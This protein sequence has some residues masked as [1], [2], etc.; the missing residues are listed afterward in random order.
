MA[1]NGLIELYPEIFVYKGATNLG[2]IISWEDGIP[3]A[4]LIDSGT[5]DA[6]AGKVY[7]A[8][9]ERFP[10][11][12]I[13]VIINTHSHADHCGGNAWFYEHC[14]PEGKLRIWAT[15]AEKS[16]I[17]TPLNQSA[18]ASGG[19]PLPEFKASYYIARKSTV[20][21]VIHDG[22]EVTISAPDAETELRL[23]FVPL[24]GHYMDMVGVLCI[25][26]GREEAFFAGDGIFGRDML[27]NYWVPFLFDVKAFKE[28]LA[29]MEKMQCTYYIP[30]H[31]EINRDISELVELN[32]ISVISNE[33]AIIQ[34][35]KTPHTA[36]DTLKEFADINDIPLR[37]SQH[38]F[39]GSTLRSYISYL[40]ADG[41]IKWTFR[42]NRLLWKAVE[43]ADTEK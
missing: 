16:G 40:Y 8:I 39:V 26:N 5:D 30:S 37:L 19:F 35:L 10:A 1:E 22:E 21:D 33:K 9:R 20:T 7:S 32:L 36:E 11:A 17:E 2:I 28:S 23:R 41:R 4:Y 6:Y 43:N 42:E 12:I 34:I 27:A 14:N 15:E 18:V 38:L 3:Y 29:E 24:P 25:R 31:G 13:K